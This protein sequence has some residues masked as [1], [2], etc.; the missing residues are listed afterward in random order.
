[1]ATVRAD[2]TD[3]MQERLNQVA[4]KHKEPG[5][6]NDSKRLIKSWVPATNK[7]KTILQELFDKHYHEWKGQAEKYRQARY[8]VLGIFTKECIRN[9]VGNCAKK[10]KTKAKSAAEGK[11][12]PWLVAVLACY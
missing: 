3:I 1:M 4:D 12:V 5:D 7:E 8:E 6:P 2:I 9:A 11:I 10:A